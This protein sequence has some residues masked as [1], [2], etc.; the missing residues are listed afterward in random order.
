MAELGGDVANAEIE[1]VGEIG[2]AV[3]AD[4]GGARSGRLADQAGYA[5][6]A[7]DLAEADAVGAEQRQALANGL[8][9]SPGDGIAGG[10][11]GRR[12]GGGDDRV[13]SVGQLVFGL[14]HRAAGHV[15]DRGWRGEGR[16]GKRRQAGAGQVQRGEDWCRGQPGQACGGVRG[17]RAGTG[18]RAGCIGFNQNPGFCWGCLIDICLCGCGTEQRDCQDSM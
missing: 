16:G 7:R 10:S 15:I 11:G 1:A 14:C 13:A 3:D 2:T 9:S 4:G 18:K 12:D 6:A 5:R 17:G 8:G